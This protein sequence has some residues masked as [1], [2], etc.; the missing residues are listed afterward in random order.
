MSEEVRIG[1]IMKLGKPEPTVVLG[2]QKH[3]D[4]LSNFIYSLSWDK[5]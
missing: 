3:Q 2:R 1:I 4:I 5:E